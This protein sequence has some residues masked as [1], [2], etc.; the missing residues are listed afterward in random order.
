MFFLGYDMS[1]ESYKFEG[2]HYKAEPEAFE[3]GREWTKVAE[4]LWA[5]GKW[6]PHPQRTGP[7]GL[8]GVLDGLNVMRQGLVSGQ[9][10]VYRVD[11]TPWP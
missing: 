11:D 7:N 8:M 1:G 6:K 9:K 4:K 3:F 10:L 2:E 5:E